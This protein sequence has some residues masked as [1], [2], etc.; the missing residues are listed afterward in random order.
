MRF[1]LFFFIFLFSLNSNSLT[2]KRDGSV[3]T[4]S[5]EVLKKP[6]FE[7][8]QEALRNFENNE[9]I[10]DWPIV[11][12]RKKTS[13]FMGEGIL[14]E[15]APLFAIPNGINISDP[16]TEIA[17]QNGITP[18]LFTDIMIAHSKEEWSEEKGISE[19]LK[20][21]YRQKIDE[22]VE[23]DF[24][25]FKLLS[26]AN[27]FE[28]ITN[29]NELDDYKLDRINEKF[30]NFYDIDV[31]SSQEIIE[32]TLEQITGSS[33]RESIE[34]KE[35]LTLQ[36]LK[37]NLQFK[38]GIEI[39]DHGWLNDKLMSEISKLP[40]K[41]FLTERIVQQTS[42][43]LDS[44]IDQTIK[45]MI[46]DQKR[47]LQAELEASMASEAIK[48]AEK[49]VQSLIKEGAAKDAI[50]AARLEVQTRTEEEYNA[51]KAAENERQGTVPDDNCVGC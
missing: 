14:E 35:T 39:N 5:G 32:I 6:M 44:E 48:E 38:L 34:L 11:E 21:T 40:D 24:V 23:D 20:D 33:L 27:E 29:L 26:I 10:E 3:V 28:G 51:L 46:V 47:V 49:K 42:S 9:P 7:R 41:E 43:E 37:D 12:G 36:T 50:E 31:K 18:E 8:Y 2:F 22:V 17:E 15:G 30:K 16:L 1:L 45:T 4:N 19:D 13:G 25:E